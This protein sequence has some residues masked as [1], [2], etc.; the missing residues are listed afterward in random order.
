MRPDDPALGPTSITVACVNFE[1]VPRNKAATL[2]KMAVFIAEAVTL[3]LGDSEKGMIAAV[4]DFAAIAEW[5]DLMPWREWRAGPQL[6]V[7]RLIADEL[8]K[9]A[10]SLGDG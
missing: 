1:A 2:E 6:P 9:I 8:E 7:S 3:A 10:S 5:Y 4:V